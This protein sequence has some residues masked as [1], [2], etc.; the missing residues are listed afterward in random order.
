MLITHIQ[1]CVTMSVVVT[2]FAALIAQDPIN[3]VLI[4]LADPQDMKIDKIEYL[5]LQKLQTI[6][7]RNGETTGR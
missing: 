5:P 6:S 4:R 3:I 7:V 1:S 2:H